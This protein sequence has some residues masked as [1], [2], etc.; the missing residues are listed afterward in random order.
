MEFETEHKLTGE[1]ELILVFKSIPNERIAEKVKK[2]YEA[3]YDK[4]CHEVAEALETLIIEESF[5]EEEE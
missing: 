1:E 3:T 2:I 4:F 5:D